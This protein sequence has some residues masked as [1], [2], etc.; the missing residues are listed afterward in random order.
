[1]NDSIEAAYLS[2]WSKARLLVQHKPFAVSCP[3]HQITEQTLVQHM[4]AICCLRRAQSLTLARI[5]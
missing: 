2:G 5:A 3:K 1:M 4:S